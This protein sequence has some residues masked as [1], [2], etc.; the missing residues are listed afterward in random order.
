MARESDAI[1]VKTRQVALTCKEARS[2][3]AFERPIERPQSPRCHAVNL[4]CFHSVGDPACMK[5]CVKCEPVHIAADRRCVKLKQTGLGVGGRS[6]G[7]LPC[8]QSDVRSA[9]ARKFPVSAEGMLG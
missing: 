8:L 6:M 9:R 5:S 2:R 3:F 4:A 7:L 1:G